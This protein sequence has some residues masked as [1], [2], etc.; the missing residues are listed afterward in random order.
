MNVPGYFCPIIPK[1]DSYIPITYCDLKYCNT[2]IYTSIQMFEL[3]FF[4]ENQ[5]F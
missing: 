1:C 4:K 3:I 2:L 5:Y